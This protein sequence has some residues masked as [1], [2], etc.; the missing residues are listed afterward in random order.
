MVQLGRVS[1]AGLDRPFLQFGSQVVPGAADESWD[2]FWG[3]LRGPRREIEL[4]GAAHLSFTDL[5]TLVQQSGAPADDLEPAFG[6]ID[7]LRSIAVQRAYVTAFF[8]RYLRQGDG[9]LLDRPSRRYPEV[10]FRR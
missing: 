1:T 4:T 6:R 2:A 7:G 3:V 9:R 8:D 5:H 10:V